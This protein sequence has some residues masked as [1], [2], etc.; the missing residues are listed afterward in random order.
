MLSYE[1]LFA[2]A[3]RLPVA[4]RIQLVTAV[5]D[6]L[7]EETVTPVSDEQ[8][9]EL[10]RRL[11]AYEANPENVLTWNQVLEQLRERM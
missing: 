9:A 6:S 1:S 3:S 4:D 11:D 10:N 5:W 2:D 8:R 7:P